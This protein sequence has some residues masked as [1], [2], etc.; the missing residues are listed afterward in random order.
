MD[1]RR[2]QA[3]WTLGRYCFRTDE[4][5]EVGAQMMVQGFEGP[6]DLELV[7]F[8][9]PSTLGE[10]PAGLVD[11]AFSEAGRPPMSKPEAAIVLV[12]PMAQRILEGGCLPVDGAMEM[13]DLAPW[14]EGGDDMT[15]FHRLDELVELWWMYPQDRGK[16]ERF[17]TE[18]AGDLL[19]R[20]P[21]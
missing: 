1:L 13:L 17:I 14:G 19:G 5:P 2:A 12:R 20:R 16:Y 21:S 15:F 6:A 7:S 3:E 10:L 18:V 4:L 9:K 8:H 11:R